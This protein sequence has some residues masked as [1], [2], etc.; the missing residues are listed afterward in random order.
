MHLQG[1]V[2]VTSYD[3]SRIMR[4]RSYHRDKNKF[5]EEY[6]MKNVPGLKIDSLE[7]KNLD[8]DTLP[9][10]QQFKFSMPVTNTGHYHLLSLNL[11]TGL[12]KN[13]F[14]SDTR[15]TNIDYG[16]RQHLVVNAVVTLPEGWQPETLPRDI[17]L[18][19]P[20]TSIS[21]TRMS[22]FEK[23]QI[24]LSVRYIVLTNRPVF[25]AEEYAALKEFY[26]KMTDILNEQIVLRRKTAA[27]P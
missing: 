18:I 24:R 11:F 9:L 16:C 23:E 21:I 6:Y 7:L 20:D 3:Y 22:T 27:R 5:S 25:V 1:K 10:V 4:E 17:R 8:T 26:K 19:M 14:L 2:L 13:P 12:E 15:F